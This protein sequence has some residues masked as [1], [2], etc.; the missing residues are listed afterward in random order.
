MMLMSPLSSSKK[1]DST[2]LPGGYFFACLFS[3]TTGTSSI[4]IFA[5]APAALG[6]AEQYLLTAN[7]KLAVHPSM[8]VFC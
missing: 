4:H 5:S 6:S 3:R 2:R 7:A 8:R 1:I